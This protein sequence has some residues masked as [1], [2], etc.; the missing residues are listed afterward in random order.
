MLQIIQLRD[1]RLHK[2]VKSLLTRWH[3]VTVRDSKYT[4]NI[5]SDQLNQLA[6]LLVIF[7]PSPAS[8]TPLSSIVPVEFT[9]IAYINCRGSIFPVNVEHFSFRSL[10]LLS[11]LVHSFIS[12]PTASF[13]FLSIKSTSLRP[14]LSNNSMQSSR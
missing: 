1:C 5:A 2:A 3:S 12:I 9:I 4:L 13:Q 7:N 14:S 8:I 10:A 6:V 11:P